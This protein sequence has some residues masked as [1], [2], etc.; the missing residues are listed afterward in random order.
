MELSLRGFLTRLLGIREAVVEDVFIEQE[1]GGTSVIVR[2]RLREGRS[3]RCSRCAARIAGDG[4]Q[5]RARRWRH[6]SL[7]GVATY[8]EAVVRRVYCP[9]TRAEHVEAVPWARA[10]ARI[11]RSLERSVALL[12]R[13]TDTTT[14]ARHFELSWRT[15]SAIERRIA[16]EH[17][18]PSRFDGLCA[19]GVDEISGG[20][21]QSY[22]TVVVDLLQG[23]VIWIG[24]G[25]SQESLEA[26]F[27][28]I[29]PDRCAQLRVVATDLHQAYHLA[30]RHFA[31]QADLVFDHFH[32]VKLL[33]TAL[34]DMR[35]E[36]FRRLD[37]EDRRWIKGTRWAVLKDPSHLSESQAQKLADLERTNQRLFRGYLLKEDFRHAWVP[38]DVSLSRRRLSR[39]LRWAMRS[40]IRQIVRFAKTVKAHLDGILKAIELRLSTGPVEGLNNK[41][42]TVL[43]RAY[44][45]LRLDH[46]IRAIYFRCLR[47]EI[48]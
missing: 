18:V 5:A 33:N 42:K 45:F 48:T 7:L 19:I 29:G 16:D 22:L 40:R 30:V 26:F 25:R 17:L 38:G 41:I 28:E 24:K 6:L 43:K 8:L 47:F 32:L 34:D 10:G 27:R 3:P 21:G 23:D 9:C 4:H 13:T 20:R 11:T 14:A 31:P 2:I 35:R 15:V 46:F 12:S 44:G 36:E 37:Q 39:W 1:S